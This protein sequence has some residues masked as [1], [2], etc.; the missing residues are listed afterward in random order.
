M[1]ATRTTNPNNLVLATKKRN[2]GWDKLLGMNARNGLIEH[3]NPAEAIRP[4][5]DR[6]ATEAVLAAKGIPVTPTPALIRTKPGLRELTLTGHP[7]V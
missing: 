5:N 4:I 3:E 7:T 2:R 6:H 1:T